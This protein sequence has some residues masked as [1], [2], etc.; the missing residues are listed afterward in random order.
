[1]KQNRNTHK[2]NN[3]KSLLFVK[4]DKF[5]NVSKFDNEKRAMTGITSLRKKTGFVTNPT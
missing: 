3:A 1:M 5:T 2:L 4:R